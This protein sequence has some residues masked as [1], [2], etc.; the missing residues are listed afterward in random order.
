[1]RIYKFANILAIPFFIVFLLMGY[2]IYK[3]HN[4]NFMALIIIPVAFLILIYL[5]SPQI[6]Y[7]WLKKHPVQLDDSIIKMLKATNPIYSELSEEKKEDF[8]NK[9]MLH[10][11]GREFIGKGMEDDNRNVPH[12][13]KHMIC[14]VPVTMSLN[15]KDRPL[16]NFER[17]VLY[18]HPFP[19]PRYKFLHT[20]ETEVEDGVVILSLEHVERALF[21]K[22]AFYNVAWHAYAEAFIK[23]R[24]KETYPDLPNDIW[25]L[26]EQISPLD[27]K[28]ITGTLGYK[29]IDP[30]PVI[31]NLYFN[32]NT[33]LREVMPNI[34]QSLDNIFNPHHA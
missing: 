33:R 18:K 21:K 4:S 11:E 3:D 19:S 12:D 29:N 10:V 20:A 24:P 25:R 26:I 1:M 6:N 30:L 9:L 32:Y 13:V 8:R 15:R 7:W 27:Q 2:W 14:Q 16:K 28:Q 17:V 34:G 23:A 22:D 5:F 31:I